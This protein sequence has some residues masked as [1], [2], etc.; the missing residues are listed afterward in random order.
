[1]DWKEEVRNKAIQR[2]NKYPG[3]WS[4]SIASNCLPVCISILRDVRRIDKEAKI[5]IGAIIDKKVGEFDIKKLNVIYTFSNNPLIHIR[6]QYHAWIE[7]SNNEV[8]DVAAPLR[9][10]SIE[11]IFGRSKA[12]AYGCYYYKI[13]QKKSDVNK[14]YRRLR[15]G[16]IHKYR[17]IEVSSI[18]N[19][20]RPF[21]L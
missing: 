3:P 18:R 16:H 4:N 15:L 14:F 12:T 19:L 20:K 17:E 10:G 8:F 5:V 13:L 21:K 2:M 9:F 6:P 11:K 1:M 7:L